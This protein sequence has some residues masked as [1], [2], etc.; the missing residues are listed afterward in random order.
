MSRASGLIHFSNGDRNPRVLY[1]RCWIA[2]HGFDPVDALHRPDASRRDAH[3]NVRRPFFAAIAARVAR[4][5]QQTHAIAATARARTP[6]PD[7]HRTRT[8]PRQVTAHLRRFVKYLTDSEKAKAAQ[9]KIASNATI[10][11]PW[12]LKKLHNVSRTF[13]VEEELT[14]H[15][16]YAN[17]CRGS[18]SAGRCS[19]WGPA[20]GS[21]QGREVP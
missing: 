5:G 2:G 3:R 11:R 16:V 18:G 20:G 19:S 4:A 10:E 12:L 6:S 9:R 14:E 21:A 17:F 8:A 1:G 13:G 15:F 7:Q